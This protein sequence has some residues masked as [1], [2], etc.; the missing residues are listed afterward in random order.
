MDFSELKR[1]LAYP[2]KR[3]AFEYF[4]RNPSLLFVFSKSP[5]K[6]Y[7]S[8]TLENISDS[9]LTSCL[10]NFL[11]ERFLKHLREKGFTEDSGIYLIL[12]SL[13]RAYKPEIVVETRVARG[14]SSAFILCAMHENCK[15]H[16]YSIDLHPY[17]AYIKIDI[18]G[19]KVLE[20]GQ[21]WNISSQAALVP[22]LV[23]DYLKERWTLI[24]GDAKKELPT[25]LE[26][27]GKID[28]FFHDSLH[29]YEH[30][31]FE[32]ETAW[33]YIK[34]HGLLLSHDV[35]WNK[36]FLSFSKKVN[37]KPLIYYSFGVIKND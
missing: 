26:K 37:K 29:T 27:I 32:Y 28:I 30:M 18:D 4:L 34:N 9:N 11:P 33:P 6:F 23:P 14:S 24:Y 2:H 5:S 36:A 35:L 10:Y 13:I 19:G 21:K 7:F 8:R 31:L 25:L 22:E 20:D 17:D 1:K 15:G 12:Y 16:L 3:T